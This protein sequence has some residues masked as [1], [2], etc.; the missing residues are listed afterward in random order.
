MAT[1]QISIYNMAL[2]H[3]GVSNDVQSLTE[4]S[5]EAAACV[6]FYDPARQEMLRAGR[7]PF[8]TKTVALAQVAL[9]PTQEWAFSYRYPADALFLH[10]I[11]GTVRNESRRD[12]VP[13]RVVSDDA[14]RLIYTDWEDLTYGTLCE[15]T[16]DVTDPAQF[17]PMFVQALAFLLASYIGKRI[18]NGDPFKL[19]QMADQL[20]ARAYDVAASAAANEEQQEVLPESEFIS[21]REGPT[22]WDSTWFPFR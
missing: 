18:T 13:Y 10:R 21:A 15:Y 14:G 8:A 11:L 7:W 6:R 12:R 20:R 17:D 19:A 2:S 3:V 22:V 5:T 1:D 9:N 16:K 4:T